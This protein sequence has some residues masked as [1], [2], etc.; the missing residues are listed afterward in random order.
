VYRR[1]RRPAAPPERDCTGTGAYCGELIQF[2][3]ED[4]PGYVD[5]PQNGET[6]ENQYRSFARRDLVMLVKWAT[7]YVA[8]HCCIARIVGRIY[9]KPARLTSKWPRNSAFQ[10]PSFD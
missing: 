9:P 6:W 7:A 10:A 1:V 4:G 8:W 5:Y 3:P 2:A